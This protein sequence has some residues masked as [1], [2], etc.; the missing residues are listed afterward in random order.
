MIQD[1]IGEEISALSNSAAMSGEPVAYMFWGIHEETYTL[2]DTEFR[3]QK[4]VSEDNNEPL[5]HYL[6]KNLSPALSFHFEED[7]IEGKRVVLL[8]IPEAHGS[9]TSY[10]GGCYFRIGS[11]KEILKE[12]PEKEATLF[13]I[14]K[15]KQALAERWELQLSNFHVK[16]INQNLFKKY[17]KN[18]KGNGRFVPTNDDPIDVLNY[19]GVAQG[20]VLLNAGAAVFV[21]GG[22]NELQMAK[23]ATDERLTILDSVRFTGSILGLMEKAVHYI[24]ESMDWRAE[25]NGNIS[26]IE[27]P[28]VP[29]N[30]IREAVI[31]AFAHRDMEARQAVDISIFKS[32]IDIYSYGAFPVDVEPE[33]F[34]R[35]T[36]KPMRRNPLI[37]KNLYYAKEMEALATGLK[38]IGLECFHAGVKYCFIKDK[39]GFTVRFFRHCGDGWGFLSNQTVK[40]KSVKM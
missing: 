40:M 39:N 1:D 38:R 22:L 27:I 26:R 2:T 4:N 32:F 13:N 11:R 8:T 33:S 34:I 18:A 23:F 20:D 36:M 3:Y 21:D 35:T 14:L 19:I 31:N 6:N 37:T 25:F 12:F 30:A 9:P 15:A 10:K 29:L 7:V 16:D 17:L 24:S 28:E 5:Q